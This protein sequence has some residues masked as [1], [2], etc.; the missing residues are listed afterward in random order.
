MRKPVERTSIIT[1]EMYA[2]L[3]DC[4]EKYYDNIVWMFSEQRHIG[5]EDFCVC[6]MD[7]DKLSYELLIEIPTLYCDYHRRISKPGKYEEFNQYALIDLIELVAN[8]SKDII[9]RFWHDCL[10]LR[11]VDLIFV[12]TCEIFSRYRKDINRI[13]EKTGLLFTLTGDKIVERVVENSVL[14][15]E[16]KTAVKTV[17][18]LGTR[19]LLEEAITL[20]LHP[21]PA[22]RKTAVEKIWDALERL[23]TY[24]TSFDK[25]ASVERIINDISNGHSEFSKLFDEEFKA[26]T[27]IGNGF[28]IRHHET[29]KID[30]TDSR[31][32]DYFFNRCLSLI[33]L[34]VQYLDNESVP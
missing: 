6:E 24:Y 7:I 9:G 31:H 33:S 8:N 15:V 13:F 28:R 32:Y 2:L 25:K 20:F 30:I 12:N 4:C 1:F 21:N 22:M 27:K 23:K 19:E 14:T 3:F 26:L 10:G 29:N 34:A 11:H 18:E 16:V 5:K 17:K